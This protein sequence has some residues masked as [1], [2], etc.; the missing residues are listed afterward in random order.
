M[1]LY[2]AGPISKDPDYKNKFEAAESYLATWKR[3]VVLNPGSLPEGL[4]HYTNYMDIGL[5]MLKAADGIVMLRGWKDSPGAR[6][7]LRAA[8]K[9][10]LKV[11]YGIESVPFAREEEQRENMG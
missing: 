7:E 1:I 11:F 10:G 3:H 9:R 8:V 4:K 6:I 5:Q 2:L